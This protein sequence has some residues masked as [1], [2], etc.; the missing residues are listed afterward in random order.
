MKTTVIIPAF[1]E[2]KTIQKVIEDFAKASPKAFIYIIDNNST[3][4]TQMMA[5]KILS[6]IKA[7]GGVLFEKKQGKAN[8][9]RKAFREIESDY[10]VMVDA[11]STYSPADLPGLLKPV[12]EGKADM[13][14]GN[15]FAE[16]TYTRQNKRQFHDFGNRL[17]KNLINFIFKSGL[18][19][20]LSGY[21]VFNRKF[22]KNFPVLSEGFELEIEIT[23]HALDKRFGILEVPINYSERPKGSHSKLNTFKDGIKVIR[24]IFMIFKDYKPLAFF[25]MLSLLC[26]C[27]GIGIGIP[28]IIEYFKFKY[29]YKV[30][31]AVLSTGLMLF[32]MLLLSIGLILDTVVKIHKSDYEIK[33]NTYRDKTD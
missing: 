11:D 10:Y 15:R 25:G 26:L 1:N 23:L 21:R 24:K 20:I 4:R 22:V 2:E 19:D 8:A 9:V 28:V 33:L 32:S 14:V 13:T 16:G 31:S 7:K 5:Q 18:K 3:D 12:L 29:V 17:V 27:L 30:P 6:R